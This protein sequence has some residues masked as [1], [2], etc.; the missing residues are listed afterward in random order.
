[1]KIFMR[2]SLPCGFQNHASRSWTT[3]MMESFLVDVVDAMRLSHM[4]NAENL[5]NWSVGKAWSMS[6]TVTIMTSHR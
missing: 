1:M 4:S 6:L 5:I 3:A 2:G